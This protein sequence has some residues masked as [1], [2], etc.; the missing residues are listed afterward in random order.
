MK[1]EAAKPKRSPGNLRLP[2]LQIFLGIL[3]LSGAAA[4]GYVHKS[5]GV[6]APGNCALPPTW[7]DYNQERFVS[8]TMQDAFACNVTAWQQFYGQYSHKPLGVLASGSCSLPLNWTDYTKERFVSRELDNT[9][10][11]T[12]AV[13]QKFYGQYTHKSIGT[14]A[15]G[16]C[17]LPLNWTDYT[18][19]RFVSRTLQDAFA[20]G[21]SAWQQ[22]YGQYGHKAMGTLSAGSCA[23]TPVWTD[24]TKERFVSR[25][26]RDVFLC[27]V[28]AWQQFYGQ[29]SHKP[30]GVLASGSCSLPLNWTDYT[31]ERFVSRSVQNASACPYQSPFIITAVSPAQQAA[32]PNYGVRINLTITNNQAFADNFTLACSGNCTYPENPLALGARQGRTVIVTI[33][34]PSPEI[35]TSGNVPY[36]V[37]FNI[38]SAAN[39]SVIGFAYAGMQID[40]VAWRDKWHDAYGNEYKYRIPVTVANDGSSAIPANYAVGAVI[41]HAALANQSKSREN[42]YDLRVVYLNGTAYRDMDRVSYPNA[43]VQTIVQKADDDSNWN[44]LDANCAANPAYSY[45]AYSHANQGNVTGYD[46]YSLAYNDSSWGAGSAP[47]GGSYGCITSALAS[48]PDD[49]F[50]R[51]WFNLTGQ[52]DFGTLYL[53]YGGGARCYVNGNLVLDAIAESHGPTYWDKMIGLPAGLLKQGPNLLACWVANGGENSGSG[54]GWFDA[55]LDVSYETWKMPNMTVWFATQAQVAGYGSDTGYYIY[56]GSPAS[57]RAPANGSKIFAFYEDFSGLDP[58]KWTEIDNGNYLSVQGGKL[59]ASGGSNG[60]TSNGIVSN[61]YFPRDNVLLEFGYKW[62]A[63]NSFMFGWKNGLG[64]NSYTDLTYGF[65]S[66]GASSD[67]VYEAGTNRGDKGSWTLNQSYR[68]RLRVKAGGGALYERSTDNGMSWSTWYDSSYSTAGLLKVGLLN[69]GQAFEAGSL[70]VRSYATPEPYA[71]KG[72]EQK[73]GYRVL[74]RRCGLKQPGA[75]MTAFLNNATMAS[76]IADQYGVCVIEVPSGAYDVRIIFPDN[77]TSWKYGQRIG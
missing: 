55:R 63:G 75:N 36:A 72:A 65:Y 11:C 42:A 5:I 44:T 23:L 33:H 31:K 74:V 29:Y 77:A 60:W 14:L 20:C 16:N 40:T 76:C 15:S 62:T 59:V 52:P 17:S 10:P 35:T 64:G 12:I 25:T 4:Q 70:F 7:A 27:N 53:A 6:L 48:A 9:F 32:F 24:Y 73:S 38:T 50:V 46:W 58:Y 41:D 22:F 3:L 54:R 13:W 2:W 18:K 56:Y 39:S 61:S 57:G 34:A 26:L 69:Y 1:P 21:V 47:F 45:K 71:V 49:L 28:S 68:V 67:D 66:N 19:E 43:S 37:E 8:C 30:L 51:K